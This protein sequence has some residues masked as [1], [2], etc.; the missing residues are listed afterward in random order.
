MFH[1]VIQSAII[2]GFCAVVFY[3][4]GVLILIDSERKGK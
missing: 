4:V 2:A 3:M 1:E